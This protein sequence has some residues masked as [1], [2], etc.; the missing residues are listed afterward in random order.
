MAAPNEAYLRPIH[1]DDMDG[2]LSHATVTG[3]GH[4][5]QLIRTVTLLEPQPNWAPE[6]RATSNSRAAPSLASTLLNLFRK[7]SRVSFAREP[8][9]P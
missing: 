9:V 3:Y 2:R 5:E 6:S 7:D 4:A 8:E 1:P